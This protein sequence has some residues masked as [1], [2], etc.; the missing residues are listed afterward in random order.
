MSVVLLW[1]LKFVGEFGIMATVIRNRD[2]SEEALAQ[3]NTMGVV[4]GTGSFLLACLLAYPAA[5]FF[6]TPGVVPV[7]VVTCI[8]LIPLGVRSVSEGLM[9]REMRFKSLTL[10]DALRDIASAVVTVLLAWLGFHY[11][12]LVLGNL[13]AELTRCAIILSVRP[14]RYAWPRRATLRGPLTFG[15]RLL[16]SGFAWS[17][18]NSL[19][20]VTAGRVLGQAALGLYA[21]AWNLANMPLEKIVSLVTTL[22]PAYLSRVQ[23]DLPALRH[24]VRSLTEMIALTTF[25]ATIGLALVA[26]EVVPLILGR[27]WVGMI[28][29][30]QVLCAYAAV[31]S[32]VAILPKV[33]I[34]CGNPRFVMRVEV[35]G[36]VIMP[37]SFWI[38]S[39][40]GIK[41]IAFGWVFG[42]PL[43]A[44]TQ[45]WKAM[46]T[47]QMG[48]ADYV[49]ALRPALDGTIAMALMV[50]TL[51]RVLPSLSPWIRLLIEISGGAAAYIA[52]VTLL[53]HDRATHFLSIAMRARKPKAT[54]AVGG[55]S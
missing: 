48:V 34:A 33:L 36:L 19:D 38:G 54:E 52:T 40:W 49:K 4:F 31:R 22:I 16:V 42:Y 30:F 39:H 25:P 44:L 6:K 53:H 18:Y 51:Q 29:P 28:A 37:I 55:G 24:Y 45:Y 21:M 13:L 7:A 10:F 12:A 11:W 5:R 20:N 9:S 1:Y 46:K 2:L 3:L 8:G 47:I 43:I 41:G 35:A 15:W 50:G 32:I 17:T 23:K 14:H 27:K 26:G